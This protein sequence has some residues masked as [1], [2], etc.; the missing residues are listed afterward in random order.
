MSFA[1]DTAG[2]EAAKQKFAELK[3]DGFAGLHVDEGQLNGL[4]YRYP[5]STSSSL[6]LKASAAS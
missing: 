3:A 5:F 4:G 1:I 6:A 2:L